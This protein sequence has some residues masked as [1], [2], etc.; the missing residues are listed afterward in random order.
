MASSSRSSNLVPCVYML[1]NKK[2]GTLYIGVTSNIAQRL[3]QH[4]NGLV[5]GFTKKRGT[6]RLVWYEVHPTMES[7][8][9]REKR[10]KWWQRDWKVQL[11]E[12]MNPAWLDLGWQV[13]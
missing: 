7:A 1:T 3:W 5:G 10:L 12:E 4:K 13:V 9:T 6:H 8:I 2:R 11:I